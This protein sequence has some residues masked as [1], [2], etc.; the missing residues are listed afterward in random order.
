MDNVGGEHVRLPVW[1]TVP[2]YYGDIVRQLF[3]AGAL[4]ILI[5]APF[6]ADT[7]SVELPYEM[8]AALVLAALAALVNPHSKPL[9]LANA[10]AAGVCLLVY[11]HW[12]LTQYDTS[13]WTQFI[14]RELIALIFLIAF[15]FSLKTVRAFIL[16]QIGK[17]AKVA[18]FGEDPARAEDEPV[19]SRPEQSALAQQS[20]N[21]FG[22]FKF[23]RFRLG[24]PKG[25]SGA[26]SEGT[27]EGP[28]EEE[29]EED[30]DTEEEEVA[31]KNASGTY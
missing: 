10:V 9:L 26:G 23:G 27:Q 30:D 7:L 13:T 2:H 16:R 18:K 1:P 19:L 21:L 29:D 8:V 20:F 14:L 6:Y 17:Y 31:G 5:G 25:P 24:H 3:I 22:R 15:Y 11:E 28:S 12:A 4:L